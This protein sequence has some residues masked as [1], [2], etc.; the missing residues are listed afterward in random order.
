MN[1]ILDLNLF[2]S[3]IKNP[4]QKMKINT[5][6]IL[7]LASIVLVAPHLILA[8]LALKQQGNSKPLLLYIVPYQIFSLKPSTLNLHP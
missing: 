4:L 8:L 6:D 3:H 5:V 2:S 7:M 1:V